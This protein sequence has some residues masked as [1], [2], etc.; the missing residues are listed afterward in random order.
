MARSTHR[1][2]FTWVRPPELIPTNC[3]ETYR[4]VLDFVFVT[5]GTQAWTP[6]SRIEM[7]QADYCPDDHRTSDHRPILATFDLSA[8]E[9]ATLRE[10]LLQHIAA[11]ERELQALRRRVE[12]LDQ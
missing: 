9:D 1:R 3:H 4:S 10:A 7:A 11:I 12:R 5:E 8:R 2:G 6:S